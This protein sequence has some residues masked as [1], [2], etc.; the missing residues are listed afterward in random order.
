MTRF[1]ATRSLLDACGRFGVSPTNVV[2]HFH[3][4]FEMPDEILQLTQPF[5]HTPNTPASQ[6]LRDEVD[7]LNAFFERH[8][9][10]GAK[11]IGWVRKFHMAY[12]MP[13]AWNK[14]GR[15]YSQPSMPA[16]N[17]QQMPQEQRLEL[18]LDGKQVAEIDISASYLTIFYA[19]HGEQIDP[20]TAYTNVIGP[21]ELHR[22]I[23]K[24]W[25]NTSFGNS[26]LLTKWSPGVKNDFAKRYQ[27][28][29]WTI[30]GKRYPVRLVREA[31]LARHLLLKEWGQPR[32]GKP[33]DYGDLMYLESQIIV[34]AM[35]RLAREHDIPSLPV[36]DSL[37][38]PSSQ[39]EL[40]QQILKERFQSYTGV[41]PTLKIKRSTAWDF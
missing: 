13:Y 19:C 6:A 7:E 27:K 10:E 17:Y 28:E 9:L 26:S 22:A 34:S 33:Q 12:L 14:G 16:T 1:R 8:A 20:A 11:H 15:L 21:D 18:R 37:I 2:D 39:V 36:H 4:V 30:D 35:L 3:L 31:T 25:V 40:S 23:V 29:Q 38:I 5:R 24:T 41:V 32:K